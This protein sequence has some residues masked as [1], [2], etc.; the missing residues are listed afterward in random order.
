MAHLQVVDVR[1]ATGGAI[2]D[3]GRLVYADGALVAVLI[4]LGADLAKQARGIWYLE[5]AFGPID[6]FHHPAFG[7]IEDCL[8]WLQR[9]LK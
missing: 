5:A 9:G 6:A 1:V 2:P 4:K 8:A 3:E 7:T